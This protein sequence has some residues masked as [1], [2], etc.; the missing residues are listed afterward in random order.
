MSEE[1]EKSVPDSGEPPLTQNIRFSSKSLRRMTDFL[2]KRR[3]QP[4]KTNDAEDA[5]ENLTQ[6]FKWLSGH[7]ENGNADAS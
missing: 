2:C 3:G 4:V 1:L 7:R 5:L 6:Y